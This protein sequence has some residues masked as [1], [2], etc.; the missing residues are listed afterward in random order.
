MKQSAPIAAA[1]V[2]RRH[3]VAAQQAQA[4]E[5]AGRAADARR[6]GPAPDAHR[7][8]RQRD[9]GEAGCGH[10]QRRPCA[11]WRKGR[12][13]QRAGGEARVPGRLQDPHDPRRANW[14]R[15]RQLAH[16]ARS[17][18]DR[19]RQGE[20]GRLRD[21]VAGR[22]QGRQRQDRRQT[23]AGEGQPHRDR[24]LSDRGRDQH[25][26]VLE[27]VGHQAGQRRQRHDGH[28]RRREDAG[29]GQA[30][31]GQLV[32]VERQHDQRQQVPGRREEDGAG[33]QAQLARHAHPAAGRMFW[34]SRK[35]FSGSYSALIRAS[36]AWL[37]P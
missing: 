32:H 30:A 29:H 6:R 1:S 23:L 7:P 34:F 8:G 26:D 13:Q 20:L 37:A 28:R 19:R 9:A 33:Q 12:R 15:R 25:A 17:P 4:V 3:G 27:P 10:E 16:A 31:A 14:R 24:G 2:G 22:H 5:R 18:G 36:R 21:R 35:V 11:N